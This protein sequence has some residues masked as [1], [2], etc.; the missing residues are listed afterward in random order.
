MNLIKIFILFLILQTPFAWAQQNNVKPQ[1]PANVSPVSPVN[2][3]AP[4]IVN[5]EQAAPKKER[6]EQILIDPFSGSASTASIDVNTNPDL[7]NFVD[8]TLVGLI[9]G[10]TKRIAVLQSAQGQINR[11]K[12]NEKINSEYKILEIYKDKILVASLDNNEYEVYFNN[13]IKPVER[14]KAAPKKTLKLEQQLENSLDPNVDPL[15]PKL[16][17]KKQAPV[18]KTVEPKPSTKKTKKTEPAPSSKEEPVVKEEPTVKEE[19]IVKENTTAPKIDEEEL[20]QMKIVQEEEEEQRQIKLIQ[21][22][23]EKELKKSLTKTKKEN[24]KK[25]N[26]K[27]EK[28]KKEPIDDSYNP[29]AE[30]KII[31]E[32]G[33]LN[34]PEMEKVSDIDVEKIK[35][36]LKK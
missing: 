2:P 18:K 30:P 10:E 19:P 4:V 35:G 33:D 16:A 9:V 32:D 17:P 25:P 31:R 27:K 28:E 6:T 26:I 22:E 8:Q 29:D 12:K 7:A 36:K 3:G 24:I 34:K 11:F 23:E 5:P 21:E 13:V 14:K 20:K 1:A 15:A